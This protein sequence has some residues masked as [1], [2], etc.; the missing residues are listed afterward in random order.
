MR[1]PGATLPLQ[2][3]R[4]VEFS[5]MVMGPSAGLVLADLG[6][7][8]IK[9]EPIG[10]DRTRRLL[11]SGSGYFPMYNRNKRSIAIDLKSAEGL[12]TAR[13]LVEGRTC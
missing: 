5:H 6:A 3:I 9:V 2:N 13:K 10:G 4:V 12:E 11:G 8:V 7:E 1:G